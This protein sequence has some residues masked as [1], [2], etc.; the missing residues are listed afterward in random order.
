V[1]AVELK[2]VFSRLKNWWL[3]KWKVLTLSGACLFAGFLVGMLIFGS[4]WHLP[5]A[6]GDIP[7]W[8]TAIATVGLLIGAAFTAVY[9]A[10]AFREQTRQLEEQRNVNAKQTTVLE[11]QATELRASLAERQREAVQL[12]RAQASKVDI[13]TEVGPETVT[14]RVTNNSDQSIWNADLIWDDDSMGY[15]EVTVYP[16]AEHLA[17]RIGPGESK[18][19]TKRPDDTPGAS[20]AYLR[21]RDA[22]GNAW[23]R[24]PGGYLYGFTGGPVGGWPGPDLSDPSYVG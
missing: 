17:L 6:W 3:K 9:A 4:P 18:S 12:K 5:P 21:F 10:K 15:L 19:R 13:E 1:T 22:A 14:I 8:I 11:L 20:G 2:Q 23:L 7:T 16:G 24:T